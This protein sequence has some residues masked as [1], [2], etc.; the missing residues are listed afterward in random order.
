MSEDRP[1]YQWRSMTNR[2]S[3]GDGVWGQSGI[4]CIRN[5]VNDKRYVGSACNLSERIGVHVHHLIHG[6]HH[7]SHLQRAFNKDGLASFEC[8]I[9]EFCDRAELALR[10]QYWMDRFLCHQ[11]A[12]G[13]NMLPNARTRIGWKRPEG[14]AEKISARVKAWWA[15]GA[16]GTVACLH[17]LR[18]RSPETAAAIVE[19]HSRDY[20]FKS[21][22][23]D[24]VRG[25][26]LLKLC[27]ENG[28]SCGAMGDILTGRR[29]RTMHHG[30]TKC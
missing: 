8:C 11:S 18:N 26:N 22:S 20:A 16:P 19:G 9:L 17:A 27:R 15:S 2:F 4:Y 21:P 14:D 24:V 12:N 25:R 30:W 23:G 10:E 6:R 28:L 5:K 1:I 3:R 13:Y 29:G 7:S